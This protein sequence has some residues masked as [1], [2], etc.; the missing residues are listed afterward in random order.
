MNILIFSWRGPGH[1]HAGGAEKSTHEHAKGWVK[2][3][4]SVTLFTSDYAGCK[5]EEVID[6]VRIIRNGTQILGVH[7]KAFLWFISNNQD[8]FDLVVDQFHG[9]PFF[10]PLYVRVKKLA[11][12]HELTKEVWRLNALP[13]PIN[14]I[15]AV[16]GTIL[17]PYVFKFFYRNIPFMTG[18]DST[19]EELINWG[20]PRNNIS[21]VHHGLEQPPFKKIPPKERKKTL[22]FLGALAKDK[23]IEEAIKVFSLVNAR[24][25][26]F[27]FWIAGKG[28]KNYTSYLKTMA[29]KNGLK[30]NIVFWGYVSENQKYQLLAKSHLLVNTSFREG[31]GLVVLEAASV[32]TPTVGFDVPGLRDSIIDGKTG[33]LSSR[34][35]NEASSKIL[36]ILKDNQR[37]NLLRKNGIEWAK[38]FTWKKSSTLS[39]KLIE[40]IVKI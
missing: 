36:G 33:V 13:K 31:W 25:G 20:I 10:T 27:K 2:A 18:S 34:D 7:L 4:Y 37:Y 24:G 1:P 3:G 9:I 19:K 39:L 5:P 21:V 8:K 26:K 15:P 16:L 11:F 32:G 23:G 22:I 38:K 35:P 6:G 40:K 17:E 14:L 30:Q 28:E 29:E 12:I